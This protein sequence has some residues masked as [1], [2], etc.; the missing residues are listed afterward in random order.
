MDVR[1][2]FDLE[3]GYNLGDIENFAILRA[4]ALGWMEAALSSSSGAYVSR[5][6]EECERRLTDIAFGETSLTDVVVYGDIF[7]HYFLPGRA[8][9]V[10]NTRR[11]ATDTS[12]RTLALTGLTTGSGLYHQY[13]GIRLGRLIHSHISGADEKMISRVA[14]M[15]CYT[16]GMID[17]CV[18]FI[19]VDDEGKKHPVTLSLE[20]PGPAEPV[21]DLA[22]TTRAARTR[23]FGFVPGVGL[24]PF[25]DELDD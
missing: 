12:M 13:L 6:S 10:K 22:Q 23:A 15:M 3:G 4:R 8:I 2:F 11:P 25:L 20:D 24:V 7:Y 19:V 1:V 5:V 9:D 17:H 16:V 21:D 14:S 18:N